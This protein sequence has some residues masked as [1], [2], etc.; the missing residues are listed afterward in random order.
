MYWRHRER[1]HKSNRWLVAQHAI[2]RVSDNTAVSPSKASGILTPSSLPT[3]LMRPTLTPLTHQS[4]EVESMRTPARVVLARRLDQAEFYKT[5][6]YATQGCN[7]TARRA[8][9]GG[10][11]RGMQ[12]ARCR[13][14]ESEPGSG[15]K[16]LE[17]LRAF[18]ARRGLDAN[19]VGASAAH[20]VPGEHK[21]HAS[22]T[23]STG[24]SR[25]CCSTKSS[26]R[27]RPGASRPTT[28]RRKSGT[29]SLR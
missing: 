27:T 6:A 5:S 19:V 28:A 1:V 25:S 7:S 15:K 4:S 22:R 3:S 26:G 21:E 13:N 23:R 20:S 8:R 14:R 16:D 11:P 17:S 9:G 10:A 29:W 18:V 24:P 12:A 2:F